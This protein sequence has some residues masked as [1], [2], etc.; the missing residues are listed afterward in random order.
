MIEAKL[1]YR[2]RCDVCRT[3]FGRT[4]S[5]KPN[6]MEQSRGNPSAFYMYLC[7]T[8]VEYTGPHVCPECA[9]KEE[10]EAK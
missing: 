7:Y 2:A 6:E 5:T 10:G 8:R 1:V 9:E 4:H 3:P